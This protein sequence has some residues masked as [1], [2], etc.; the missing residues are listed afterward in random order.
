M[1]EVLKAIAERYSCRAYTDVMP[2]DDTLQA[3]AKAGVAAP[4]GMNRQAWRIIVVKDT[5]LMREIDADGMS[6]FKAMPDQS[7]YERMMGRGGKMLYNAPCMMVVVTEP[8][9]SQMD[10]G[11]VAQN[12]TLAATSLGL[13]SIIC[14]ILGSPLSGA[15]GE[16][17][18]KRLGFPDNYEFGIGILMGYAEKDGAPHEPDLEKIIVVE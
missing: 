9:C 16:E 10:I 11:I 15:R 5:V 12:I 18:K 4:S 1:N 13:G 8:D 17:F 6:L 2:D 3:I 7:I 14:G